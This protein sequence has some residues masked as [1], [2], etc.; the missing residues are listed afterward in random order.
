MG[1]SRVTELTRRRTRM[2][3]TAWKLALLA[4]LA[5]TLPADAQTT[6]ASQKMPEL[7]LGEP[8]NAFVVNKKNFELM[9]GQGYR[10][11]VTAKG[12]F[13]YKFMAPDFFRNVWMNQIVI[14]D[15][16]VH[17]AGAPAHL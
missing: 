12:E 14:E 7:V 17:M 3:W 9:A 5:L 16:E 8:G 4:S 2:R 13:E 15:L 10:W 11:P 1:Y 6:R